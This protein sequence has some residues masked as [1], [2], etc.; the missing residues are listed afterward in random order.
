MTALLADFMFPLHERLKGHDSVRVR[1]QMERT[2][3]LPAAEL[4]AL[5]VARLRTFLARVGTE[6]PF[7]RERFA[8]AGFDPGRIRSIADLGG[9][10]RLTKEE[11]R[12]Q[13]GALKRPGAALRAMSTGGST[14]VPLTFYLSAE[15][16]SHDVAAKWRATRWWGVDIGDREVVLWGS[17]IEVGR[18]DRVRLWRD[19][20]F[21]T[22][23]LPAFE[24]SADR[25]RG[26]LEVITRIRPRMLFG[27]P[28]ALAL[29]AGAAKRDGRPFDRLGIKVAF[30]TGEVV[31]AEQRTAIS[32]AFGCAVANGYG[33]R[34][35]GFVAHECPSGGMHVTAEDIVLELLDPEGRP[36]PPGSPGEITVTH[37]ATA[38]FPFVRYRT[39]D[40]GVAADGACAC[41][42]TLPR[43]ASIEGRRTDFVI[44]A[45]GTVMHGLAL[46]YV[47]RELPGIE[48]FRIVQ[49]TREHTRVEVVHAGGVPETVRGRIEDGFRAR[50]GAGVRIDVES[51]AAIPTEAS[52]K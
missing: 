30:V 7:Y 13:S 11:I 43:L 35:A 9:L 23:L 24:M 40:V 33:G 15:R 27:Y 26:Y 5:R 3:W 21:R 16:V 6:V 49:E 37:L 36:V 4:E 41:G 10:P 32:A 20:I 12:E 1:E 25:I 50:L 18:Q 28:S 42:R 22:T 29:L 45:D 19:R 8:R 31:Y 14:G 52:G 48:A 46:I 34:D 51:V 17:P 38:D 47:L 2:Q 39:G 44:A